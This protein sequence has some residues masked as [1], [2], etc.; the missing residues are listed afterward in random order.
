ML[1]GSHFS[2]LMLIL[3][4]VLGFLL[5][6]FVYLS[7]VFVVQFVFVVGRTC[8]LHVTLTHNCVLGCTTLASNIL[9]LN[10][11]PQHLILN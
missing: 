1:V 11:T 6:N 4:S 7:F 8:L 3:I 5:Y 2:F 10:L 9:N